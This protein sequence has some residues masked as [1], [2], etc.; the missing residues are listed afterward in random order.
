M[1]FI[2]TNFW[3][4]LI[5]LW[6]LLLVYWLGQS[7]MR[8]IGNANELGITYIVSVLDLII[9]VLFF[10]IA[11][12][13]T[14]QPLEICLRKAA[15]LE[16]H[17]KVIERVIADFPWRALKAYLIAGVAFAIY[18]IT[19][20]SLVAVL[21]DHSF[22]L[23]MFVALALNIGFGALVLAPALAVAASIVYS[24]KL[25]MKLSSKGLFV[26]HLDEVRTHKQITSA[27][28]RPWLI[29]IVTGLLPTLIL[30]LYVILS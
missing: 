2:S 14:F 15:R 9:L 28:H 4:Y 8:M 5:Y 30:S 27:S 19:T 16:K 3:C 12:W 7:T 20:I 11:A 24:S 23:R 29:L 1:N 17:Q 25:R 21:G 18:L 6:P 22:S 10:A 26:C 13:W